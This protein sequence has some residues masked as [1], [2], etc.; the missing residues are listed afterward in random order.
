MVGSLAAEVLPVGGGQG[1]L[2]AAFD[3]LEAIQWRT[4]KNRGR[5]A[6][7]DRHDALK[8]RTLPH[9]KLPRE[10][11]IREYL[12]FCIATESG[13]PDELAA[14]VTQAVLDVY[15][16]WVVTPDGCLH[17]LLAGRS[18]EELLSLRSD[19]YRLPEEVLVLVVHEL[20][21][22][23]KLIDA[24]C[25]GD[26]D[27]FAA[28]LGNTVAQRAYTADRDAYAFRHPD[29]RFHFH[30]P[31]GQAKANAGSPVS[32]KMLRKARS[33]LNVH[34]AGKGV[35]TTAI[36]A[37]KVEQAY[38]LAL[39]ELNR[40]PRHCTQ[41]LLVPARTAI[42]RTLNLLDDRQLRLA[43]WVVLA[44]KLITRT[45]EGI[46][47][48]HADLV[49]DPANLRF[50]E[51]LV[52]AFTKTSDGI[53]GRV[54]GWDHRASCAFSSQSMAELLMLSEEELRCSACRSDEDGQ[55]CYESVCFVCLTVLVRVRQRDI[56]MEGLT[57]IFQAVGA[58][59][60]FDGR[61]VCLKVQG[62]LAL[63]LLPFPAVGIPEA[64][65]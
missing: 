48:L 43:L 54:T 4:D 32:S 41:P 63:A 46:S 53:A 7:R 10:I 24:L 51:W 42:F 31:G 19:T 56:D 39:R 55:P 30:D 44:C 37:E 3:D 60:R 26:R 27:T 17:S 13:M 2:M 38:E 59:G 8:G 22:H 50:G 35:P 14:A 21:A 34:G 25:A 12:N 1:D 29:G 28:S 49:R 57:P 9:H 15:V 47:M 61:S 18:R 65:P 33:G 20:L 52:G 11:N 23:V 45:Y 62:G 64:P 40:H 58:D 16:E 6:T 36:A 5:S